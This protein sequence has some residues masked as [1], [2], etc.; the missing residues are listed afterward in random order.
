MV[1][2]ISEVEPEIGKLSKIGFASGT[3]VNTGEYLD[4]YPWA[5]ENGAKI[6]D[7]GGG[8]GGGTLPIVKAFPSL[9]MVVQDIPDSQP[10]FEKVREYQTLSPCIF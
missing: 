8:V 9:R 1:Q 5:R 7:V 3:R 4:V 6:V 10:G 2:Y